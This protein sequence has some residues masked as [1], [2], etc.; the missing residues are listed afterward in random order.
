MKAS[1]C[2][3]LARA[4]KS[5]ALV[6]R[7]GKRAVV[8]LGGVL[9]AKTVRPPSRPAKCD[10]RHWWCPRAQHDPSVGC[11]SAHHGLR[12]LDTARG[13]WEVLPCSAHQTL[14]VHLPESVKNASR[15][16]RSEH[17][18][19]LEAA[20]PHLVGGGARGALRL[21]VQRFDAVARK[22]TA[23]EI[24]RG[25]PGHR[26]PA[27]HLRCPRG[28]RRRAAAGRKRAKRASRLRD[29][30]AM[31]PRFGR[32]TSPPQKPPALIARNAYW[33]AGAAAR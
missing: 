19:A 29:S 30:V 33:C 3:T 18:P 15:D 2:K 21:Q 1:V 23:S 6:R 28:R 22:N 16:L 13:Q 20:H 5:P 11:A 7:S 27:P 31:R 32:L 25:L 4:A 9:G 26:H 12:S 10:S 14:K 24:A 17:R 8:E